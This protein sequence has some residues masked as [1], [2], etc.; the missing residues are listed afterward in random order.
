[1]ALSFYP[2]HTGGVW[3]LF[4]WSPRMRHTSRGALVWV[5]TVRSIVRNCSPVLV[6]LQLLG[7]AEGYLSALFEFC[8]AAASACFDALCGGLI[9]T[10]GSFDDVLS[11]ECLF[12]SELTV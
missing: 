1:M 8:A 2:H 4:D 10:E 6:L 5:P 11:G 9:H 7:F 3:W 12:A